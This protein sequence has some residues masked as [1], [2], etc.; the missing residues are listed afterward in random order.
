M[1]HVV[2]K[3]NKKAVA[4][5]KKNLDKKKKI[6][7]LISSIVLGLILIAGIVLIICGA[8]G[9][10]DPLNSDDETVEYFDKFTTTPKD[11]EE[12]KEVEFN[13]ATYFQVWN[14][15]LPDYADPN[16][17]SNDLFVNNIFVFA[18][19]SA[20]F[21]ADLDD[22]KDINTK[23]LHQLADFQLLINTIN[24]DE[25]K[26]YVVDT[27]VGNG[28][29]LFKNEL[30]GFNEDSSEPIGVFAYIKDGKLEKTVEVGGKA[31]QSIYSTTIAEMFSTAI[32]NAT[33]YVKTLS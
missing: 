33:Q 13:S 19:N 17:P 23:F 2:R 22:E 16:D 12:Q 10:F 8:N 9:V 7:V 5:Q 31:N 6:I 28:Y 15:A 26:L 29:N 30:F 1:A 3:V 4:G 11:G 18:Y 25:I 20:T 21:S 24:N 14:Y 27:A 32:P